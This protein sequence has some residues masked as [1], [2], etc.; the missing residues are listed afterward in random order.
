MKTLKVIYRGW[1]ERWQLGTLA[2]D[3]RQ[4]LFEYSPRALR[5]S[6]QLS[7]LHLPLRERAYANGPRFFHG[8]PGLVADALP[9]GWGLLL[10]DRA[11]RKMGRDPAKISPLERLAFVGER[12]IGALTFDPA[13]VGEPSAQDCPPD[14]R[15]RR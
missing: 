4:L 8:L 1:G 6:L 15:R 2:D 7:P 14:R 9:D 10:M 12:A 5:E 11:L 3:G 13:Q